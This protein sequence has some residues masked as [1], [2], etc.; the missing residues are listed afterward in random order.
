VFDEGEERQIS[1]QPRMSEN[2]TLDETTRNSL[3]D[4]VMSKYDKL[5]DSKIYSRLPYVAEKVP[6][7]SSEEESTNSQSTRMYH[8]SIFEGAG[9]KE[10]DFGGLLYESDQY[11]IHILEST[12]RNIMDFV[13]QLNQDQEKYEKKSSTTKANYT[14]FVKG[15]YNPKD[16]ARIT[17][18]KILLYTD[19][20]GKGLSFP[21]WSC[22]ELPGKKQMANLSSDE[23]D[24]VKSPSES[25]KRILDHQI[26]VSWIVKI[27]RLLHQLLYVADEIKLLGTIQITL[28]FE[29]LPQKHPNM[30][31]REAIIESLVKHCDE[32]FTLK[33]FVS[34]YDTNVDI[35][36][37]SE[38]AWY[39]L[40][41]DILSK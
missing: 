7:F 9:Y 11:V 28:F 36:L 29:T 13:R 5:A 15:R 23:E 4:V 2:F 27:Q 35:T 3:L 18:V 10:E 24:N 19:D 20:F 25:E 41:Q 38:L 40:Y 17:N 12:T 22:R 31:P 34:V 16:F 14:N 30:I 21:L 8:L 37:E 1:L 6:S 39:S 32:C 33:E 26:G